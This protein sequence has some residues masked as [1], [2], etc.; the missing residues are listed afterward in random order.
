M[1]GKERE[2]DDDDIDTLL[3]R[4][5]E[6]VFLLFAHVGFFVRDRDREVYSV[7]V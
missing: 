7:C 2:R 3:L 4:R 6:I 5:G 1:D